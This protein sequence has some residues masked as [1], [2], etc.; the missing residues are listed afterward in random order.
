MV[1]G[2]QRLVHLLCGGRQDGVGADRCGKHAAVLPRA[3][4]AR[5]QPTGQTHPFDVGQPPPCLEV[6]QVVDEGRSVATRPRRLRQRHVLHRSVRH[7][8]QRYFSSR[9]L[10]ECKGG[11]NTGQNG[12]DMFVP[13]SP[14]TMV[15]VRHEA[16]SQ[17]RAVRQFWLTCRSR[18]LFQ[19]AI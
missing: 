9:T 15:I 5:R 19:Q 4:R 8:D 1:V 17:T 12:I 14:H 2:E 6:E 7:A 13:S 10:L 18:W 3:G 11:P 16:M